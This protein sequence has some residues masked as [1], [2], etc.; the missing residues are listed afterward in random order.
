MMKIVS[1]K[2]CP[3]VQ[4]VTGMLEAKG[5]DYEITYIDL[6]A[7]PQWFLD[8]SPTA[9]VPILITDEGQILHESEA[10]VEYIDEITVPLIEGLSPITRAQDRAWSYQASKSY[11][12][13]CS[14]MQSADQATLLSRMETLCKAFNRMEKQLPDT[15]PFFRGMQLGNVDVAWLP[16]LHR[17]QVVK[18]KSGFDMLETFPK[19]QAWR[20]HILETGIV[21]NTV[22]EDFEERFSN[23]Y[24][25]AHTFLGQGANFDGQ[26]KKPNTEHKNTG[27]CG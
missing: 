4:R 19:M 10:I 26:V 3:F 5:L 12:V 9:Q 11:L 27:C 15:V 14:M 16:L 18:E 22:A 17:S 2:I 25:S 7:K 23:F 24:L 21:P 1:F 20:G 8:L 6:K 13:Q